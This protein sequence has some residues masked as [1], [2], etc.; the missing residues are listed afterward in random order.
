[1]EE[2]SE[3]D[4]AIFT[5]RGSLLKAKTDSELAPAVSARPQQE[6]EAKV[7]SLTPWHVGNK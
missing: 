1:M 5:E 4:P 6:L 7:G 2:H 3:R